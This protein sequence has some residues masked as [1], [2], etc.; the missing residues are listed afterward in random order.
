MSQLRIDH[1]DVWRESFYKP[2]A[3]ALP[4]ITWTPP[5][6]STLPSWRDA[7]RVSLDAETRDPDLKRLGPGV[8]RDP[9]VNYVVGIS[10]AIEDGGEWYLPIRHDGGDNCPEG[11]AAV[12][13]Y[14][15]DQLRDYRG[16]ILGA[17]L[18]Y[19]GDWMADECP[20]ILTK[21][22]MDVQIADPLIWELHMSYSLETLCE[23]YGLPGKDETVLRQAAS[24]YRV[25]PKKELW[26]LP[27]RFVGRYGETDARR[28]L[29]IMRRQEKKIAE[30]GVEQI[31]KLEQQVT[32]VLIKMKRRGVRVDMRRVEVIEKKCRQ[33]AADALAQVKSLTGVSIGYGDVWKAAVLAQALRA[34]GYSLP[35]TE[36]GADSVDKNFLDKCGEVGAAI[37]R[38]RDWNK[39]DTTYCKQ[40]RE[41]AISSGGEYR[42]HA[43][44]NQSKVTKDDGSGKGV[45]YGRTSMDSPSLQNQ[46]VRHDE[47]GPMWRSVYVADSG[48]KWATL[49]FSQQEPRIAVHYAEKL[50]LPGAKE[51]ANEYRTNPKLD[52]HQKF[53]DLT[54][55]VR[56]ICKN[57]TNARIYG[58]GDFKTCVQIGKPTERR[59]IRGEMRQ[60]PGPEG[61]AIIDSMN[62]YAPWIQGLTRAAARAAEQNGHVWTILRRKCHFER[63]PD[64]KIDRAH[65]AFNRIG[66][67]S[68]ADQLKATM[69]AA[70]AEGIPL[71]LL[72][73]D[74]LDISYSDIN[75]PM[76]LKELMMTVV[77]FSVPM[78][79]DLEIG[80]S[81]GEGVKI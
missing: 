35:K 61:Q 49:D 68:A 37:H 55:I 26:K 10:F 14:F 76:R 39:L 47:F 65:K 69:V 28:P 75:V 42:I 29:Q 17:N 15:R 67:G 58:A 62:E 7:K 77:T 12:W 44:T 36:K 63:A 59:V 70:D 3:D 72:I 2:S 40:V 20:E 4:Q 11:P 18:N 34:A 64:G 25:D 24:A 22:M 53:A 21:P 30:E 31:W 32:P 8:R 43:T 73:H 52:I 27:A 19:D 13:S 6:L 5:K 56:K 81:W 9:R 57:Y 33:V 54:G 51:F 48:C 41:F 50:G 23:R 71:Q 66:Q 78:L 16:H 60:V 46:P 38:A 79:V 74:E 1:P 45:R 80:P